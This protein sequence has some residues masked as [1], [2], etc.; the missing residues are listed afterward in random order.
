M[1]QYI[2]LDFVKPNNRIQFCEQAKK[3]IQ[4]AKKRLFVL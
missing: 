1:K 2:N 4:Q 3:M